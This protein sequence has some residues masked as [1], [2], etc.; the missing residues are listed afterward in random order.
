M[1]NPKRNVDVVTAVH[2]NPV[3]Y[4]KSYQDYKRG[5]QVYDKDLDRKLP[6]EYP[7]WSI[8]R[9]HERNIYVQGRHK[10]MI[11]FLKNVSFDLRQDVNRKLLVSSFDINA[12]C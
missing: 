5:I 9:I 7:F 3:A 1:Q 4:M 8:K 6:A 2:Y 12:I 11:R 10:K